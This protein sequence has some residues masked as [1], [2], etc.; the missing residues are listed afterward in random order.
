M[1]ASTTFSA[2]TVF[3]SD[4][5]N[6]VNRNSFEYKVNIK[7]FGG[8]ADGVTDNYAAINSAIAYLTTV[9]AAPN[10]SAK[11]ILEFG[12]GTWYCSDTIKPEHQITFK[13][14]GSPIGNATG[15]C[16]IKFPTGKTGF[17][18]HSS[19]TS[20]TGKDA[21]GTSFENLTITT[22]RG[23]AA[24]EAGKHGIYARTRFRVKNCVISLFGDCGIACE[25]TAGV[26][27][28]A[29]NWY[30]ESSRCAENG[31]DGFFVDGD[32]ANAGTAISLDCG[33]N[34]RNGIY[35]STTLGNTYIGCHTNNN[36]QYCY[37][38]DNNN[39]YSLFLGCYTE[40]GETANIVYPSLVIGGILANATHTGNCPIISSG[41]ANE[42][43]LYQTLLQPYKG[44][45]FQ[46]T[47]ASATTTVFDAYLENPNYATTDTSFTY[48]GAK[49]VTMNYTREGNRV[50]GEATVSGATSSACTAGTS[51]LTLPITP[52]AGSVCM[53]C[54]STGASLGNGLVKTDGKLYPP[55]WSARAGTITIHFNYQISSTA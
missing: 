19:Y 31:Y 44:I 50:F 8:V 12:P 5:G 27:G 34:L 21:S 11:G 47:T 13:G 40:G 24:Q 33:N 23:S 55:T 9:T 28:N 14:V 36:A 1:S 37:T 49:T 17:I 32:N 10:Y 39:Q 16:I 51:T 29:N 46:Y 25:A 26:T 4:W 48:V 42:M 2:G 30:I 45:D 54:D 22:T 3:T 7:D 35:D 53:A 52:S 41:Q 6:A 38:T 20:G 15:V 18:V 43:R